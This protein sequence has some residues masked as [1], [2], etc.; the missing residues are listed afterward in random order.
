[1]GSI[2][3]K[4]VFLVLVTFALS[5]GQGNKISE[6][7]QKSL[8]KNGK[9]NIYITF[10]AGIQSA[11]K[12][13]TNKGI[14]D[15]AQRSFAVQQALVKNAKESQKEAFGLLNQLKVAPSN[16]KSYWIKNTIFIKV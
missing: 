11:L 7:L 2:G 15:R 6:N 1:M 4:L 9:A 12:E 14:K 3:I 5:Q 16:I 10:N 8:N 13:V